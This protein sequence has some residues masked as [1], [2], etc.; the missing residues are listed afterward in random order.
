M[1]ELIV[2]Q[3]A[4]AGVLLW[5]IDRLA[6]RAPPL[7]G[8]VTLATAAV[9]AT[10]SAVAAI[11]G[12]RRWTAAASW[13]WTLGSLPVLAWGEASVVQAGAVAGLLVLHWE[14]GELYALVRMARASGPAVRLALGLAAARTVGY[15]AAGTSLAVLTGGARVI[16]A[17]P[18]YLLAAAAVAIGLRLGLGEGYGRSQRE[19]AGR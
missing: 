18:L 14:V 8:T 10:L 2:A 6:M 13:T 1:G 11:A 4:L 17:W 3:A 7:A 19:P 9:A 12:T 15:A 16:V 5:A